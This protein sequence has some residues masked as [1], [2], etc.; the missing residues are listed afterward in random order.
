MSEPFIGRGWS[1]P[2]TF[3]HARGGVAMLEDE[4]DVKSSLDILLR[5]MRGER[6]MLP[7]YG[8]NVESQ[9]FE[10]LDTRQKTLLKDL[11]ETAILYYEPRIE[12]IDV[13]VRDDQALEGVLFIEL[14][15]R[16]KSTNSRFNVVFPYYRNEGTDV[17]L[18]ASVTLLTENS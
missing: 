5:T 8:C 17:N 12:L 1:F 9:L 11:I 13:I 4:D 10:P 2:P 7:L 14:T 15:Y 18:T 3:D 16:L 6:V